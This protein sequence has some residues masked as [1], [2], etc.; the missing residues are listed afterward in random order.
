[1]NQCKEGSSLPKK[2][3][4]EKKFLSPTIV[5]RQIV[6]VTDGRKSCR[7][8]RYANTQSVLRPF[9]FTG[10]Q[11]KE[12]GQN[13]QYV[14]FQQIYSARF[15]CVKCRTDQK[16]GQNLQYVVFLVNLPTSK[17]QYLKRLVHVCVNCMQIKEIG[18]NLQYVVFQ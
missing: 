10:G 4:F 7:D 11:N 18:Q 13:L 1:M 14:V 8:Q 15:L 5:D 2:L 6:Y 17:N 9:V 16:T 12:S 3:I